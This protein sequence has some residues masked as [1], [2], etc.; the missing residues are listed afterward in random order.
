MR[1]GWTGWRGGESSAA[2]AARPPRN[3]S[4]T[5][6]PSVPMWWQCSFMSVSTG[7]EVLGQLGGGAAPGGAGR[8]V[9]CHGVGCRGPH[10]GAVDAHPCRS[11]FCA[12]AP[13]PRRRNRR[14]DRPSR[15]E[16]ARCACARL[17]PRRGRRTR[18]G[19]GSTAA[20][21]P[22]ASSVRCPSA[23]SGAALGGGQSSRAASAYARQ[24]ACPRGAA[25]GFSDLGPHG[26]A[27]HAAHA[28]A[29]QPRMNANPPMGVIAPSARTPVIASR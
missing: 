9:S 15:R 1:N 17:P 19:A 23:G 2:A 27:P 26:R 11:R 28:R 3:G 25:R 16:Q 22:S 24:P 8:L 18:Q 10:D 12:P 29:S 14:R 6:R 5:G 13:R 4:P 7:R 21:T 20:S